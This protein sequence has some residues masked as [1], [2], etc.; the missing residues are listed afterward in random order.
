MLMRRS[1]HPPTVRP[2]QTHT[3]RSPR[4]PNAATLGRVCLAGVLVSVAGLALTHLSADAAGISVTTTVDGGPGSLRAAIDQANTNPGADVITIPAGTYTL[5]IPGPNEDANATGDFD[6][7]SDITFV[8]AGATST[9]IDADGLDRV[10]EVL[11]GTTIVQGL[12]VTN[13]DAT[14]GFLHGSGGNILLGPDSGLTVQDSIV[15]HG[16]ARLGGGIGSNLNGVLTILRSEIIDNTA[17]HFMDYDNYGSGVISSGPTTIVD[18]LIAGNDAPL[19]QAALMTED[20]TTITNTTI[21]GNTSER[22]TLTLFTA[23]NATTQ[24]SLV[25]VTI[26][27]N[28][29]TSTIPGDALEIYS[30]INATLVVSVEGSLFQQN[31]VQGAPSN[32]T[33]LNAGA[34]FS[35]GGHNV[36]DDTTCTAFTDPTDVTNN[37]STTLGA[38]ADNGG[39]TRTLALVAGSSAID[40]AG[41]CGAVT[42]TDQRGL[43]RPTGA[44]CDAGAFEVGEIVPPPTTSTTTSIAVV[45]PTNPTTTVVHALPAT[46][47]AGSGSLWIAGLVASIGGLLMVASRRRVLR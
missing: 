12:T 2:M 45:P 44:A 8:G 42:P 19:G 43:A 11:D 28:S 25:H 6:I 24:V 34:S 21:T 4:P 29:T 26:A 27:G 7:F 15:S 38:L 41:A 31:L 32:C 9:I 47:S 23:N 20:D 3:N 36:T 17:A 35:S 14:E 33:S 40:A 30:G 16:T 46:G 37:Q 10:F 18:S 22:A 1:S 5:T 39:P 13:G